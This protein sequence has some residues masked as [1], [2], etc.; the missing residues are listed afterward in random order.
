VLFEADYVFQD[1]TQ[2]NTDF[3]EE[4]RKQ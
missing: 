4:L 3:L 1:F 2:M